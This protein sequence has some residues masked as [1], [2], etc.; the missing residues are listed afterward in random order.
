MES[1]ERRGRAL[2][3]RAL[4]TTLRT[5]HLLAVGA[6]YGG[7]VF[8]VPPERLAPAA[9]AV[10]AT[11]V[12]FAVFEVWSAPV[13]LVQ[14]RGVATYLKLAL[15]ASVSLFWDERIWILSLVMAIGVVVTHAPAHIRYYSV[16]HRRV[17]Y[18]DGNG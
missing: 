9:L 15:I 7:H 2:V 3:V 8:S 13:W 1:E 14:I 10:L 11:G 16:K 17:V 12:L 6:Y 4:R 18:T 5:V